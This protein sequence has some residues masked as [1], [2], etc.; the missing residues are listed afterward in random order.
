MSAPPMGV[1]SN[2]PKS[3]ETPTMI[4]NRKVRPGR[5]I[6]VIPRITAELNTAKLTM[7]CPLYVIGRCGRI[8]C[9]LPAAMRLPVKVSDPMMTS[10]DIST[11]SNFVRWRGLA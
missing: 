4:G 9:S 5:N 3:S 6:N 11:T 7:F 8:S 1:T 2:T 10:S